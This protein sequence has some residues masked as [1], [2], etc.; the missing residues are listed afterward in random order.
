MRTRIARDA[1]GNI[2]IRGKYVAL[3]NDDVALADAQRMAQQFELIHAGAVADDHIRDLGAQH[4]CQTCTK[5]PGLFEPVTVVPASAPLE[6][7]ALVEHCQYAG[8]C[9]KG[10]WANRVGI[11]I[12]RVGRTGRKAP[13]QIGPSCSLGVEPCVERFVEGFVKLDAVIFRVLVALPGKDRLLRFAHARK[14]AASASSCC[15]IRSISVSWV[16][17]TRSQLPSAIDCGRLAQSATRQW[18]AS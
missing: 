9:I 17:I 5:Q 3:R 6:A 2:T 10:H 4:A 11:E 16:R 15:A 1:F 7:P 8:G 12:K 18:P 14:P 13:A